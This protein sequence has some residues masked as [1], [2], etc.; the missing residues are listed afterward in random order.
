MLMIKEPAKP[1]QKPEMLKPGTIAD[2]RINKTALTTN[3]NSPSVIMLKG[4]VRNMTIGLINE[5]TSPIIS[6]VMIRVAMPD[7]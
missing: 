5:L 2:T 3:V 7:T 6:A 1:G 4:S